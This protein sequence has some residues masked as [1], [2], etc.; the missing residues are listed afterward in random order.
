MLNIKID[1]QEITSVNLE[2]IYQTLGWKWNTYYRHYFD[3]CL[4]M[5]NVTKIY[6]RDT[7]S[8]TF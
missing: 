7:Y 6:A 5:T 3:K 8:E 2:D 1:N 4:T